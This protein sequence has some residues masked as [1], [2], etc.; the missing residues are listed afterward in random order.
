MLDIACDVASKQGITYFLFDRGNEVR[1]AQCCRLKLKLGEADLAETRT[2]EKMRFTSLQ[3]VTINLPRIAFK[4]MGSD[5]MLFA[6]LD[7]CLEK[8]AEAHLQKRAFIKSLI[9]LGTGGPLSLFLAGSDGEPY[10]NFDRLTYIAGL[11]GLNEMVE[12]HKGEQLHESDAALKF[13]LNVISHMNLKCRELS[14]KHGIHLVIEE[15]PAESACYRLAKLDMKYFPKPAGKVIKG[16]F[17]KNEYYYTNSIHLA[18]DAPV[19]YIERVR[20]QGLFHPLM[21]AGAFVHIWLGESEPSPESIKNF[22]IKTYEHTLAEQIAFSPEFTVCEDCRQTSRGLSETCPRCDSDNVYGITRVVG[23]FS[24][25]QTWNKGKI[26]EL[27]QRVR[28]N[29]DNEPVCAQ[30][31]KQAVAG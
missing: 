1:V 5:T 29:V 13:G 15:S 12:F 31:D 24:K 23:Y 21:D 20:K 6:E 11:L 26:G 18:A 8:V 19:D 10:L 25:I 3:N 16:N 7:K 2:P 22:V 17:A 4:A 30:D 28:V 27:K 9:D 14:Q